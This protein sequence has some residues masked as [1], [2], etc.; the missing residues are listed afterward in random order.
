MA[1]QRDT[2]A[3]T[4]DQFYTN[5]KVAAECLLLVERYLIGIGCDNPFW[6][7][8][9]AGR[10]A[11]FSIILGRKIG[12]DIEPKGEGIR[13]RDFLIWSPFDDDPLIT[14]PFV[15]VGNPPFGKN[16]SLAMKFINHA[17][18]FSDV[19][20]FI[21]PKTFQKDSTKV[22]I[23][24]FLHLVLEAELPQESFIFNGDVYDV[25]CVFQI[26]EKRGYERP[27]IER[28]LNHPHFRFGPPCHAS[29]S[30]QRVGRRAGKICVDHQEKSPLSH[31]FITPVCAEIPVED[32]LRTIDWKE[33]SGRTS[34]NPSIGKAEL[35]AAYEKALLGRS[36]DPTIRQGSGSPLRIAG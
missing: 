28:K 32:I 10:G 14:G 30:F 20:A 35:V 17:A 36:P 22:R 6:I 15:T 5:Q 1:V 11:F 26:W 12:L 27:A 24:P 33:I 8:P 23:H 21:L 4:L 29:F 7:E 19:V 25:P 9:S 2:S 13:R 16:S 3:R 31:Y 34:G 18:R